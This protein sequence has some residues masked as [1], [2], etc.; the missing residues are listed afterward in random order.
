MGGEMSP[1]DYFSFDF[2]MESRK[3]KRHAGSNVLM[4]GDMKVGGTRH[5]ALLLK[6]L[7]DYCDVDCNIQRG[8]FSRG[9]HAF[10]S[11]NTVVTETE[12]TYIVDVVLAL[13]A[14]TTSPRRSRSSTSARASMR[15]RA[16]ART[17]AV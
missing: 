17:D 11:W 8:P 2:P 1:E 3:A 10:H 14:S 7:C 13:G 6:I 12:Q 16:C 15:S 5:R 9:A 4:L